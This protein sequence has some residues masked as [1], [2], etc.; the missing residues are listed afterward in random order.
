MPRG[1]R[2]DVTRKLNCRFRD[3]LNLSDVIWQISLKAQDRL[4]RYHCPAHLESR[5]L[6]QMN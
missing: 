1:L 6:A 2:K 3:R 4:G 5:A